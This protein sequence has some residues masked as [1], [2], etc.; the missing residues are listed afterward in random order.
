MILADCNCID[1][2]VQVY[3]EHLTLIPVAFS[4]YSSLYL[5]TFY[6]ISV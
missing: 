3:V 5:C 4:N 1:V 2:Y 6:I